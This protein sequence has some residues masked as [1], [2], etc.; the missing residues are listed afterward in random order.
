MCSQPGVKKLNIPFDLLYFLYSLIRGEITSLKWLKYT[1]LKVQTRGGGGS[2]SLIQT[3][4]G[5]R[6]LQHLVKF[7]WKQ[8]FAPGSLSPKKF[9]TPNPLPSRT[10]PNPPPPPPPHT[11]THT[12]TKREKIPTTVEFCTI[13]T[14]PLEHPPPPPPPPPTITKKMLMTIEFCIK[15][16][17][18]LVSAI[19]NS[20]GWNFGQ[21]SA[22]PL[23]W[24]SAN[25]ALT[26][27]LVD[28]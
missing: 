17:T 8:S 25:I 20:P 24:M 28:N 7:S 13:K 4:T 6:L 22:C 2:F 26:T 3:Q 11:H 14:Y 18:N 1:V 12:N 15:K 5:N 27:N 21:I 9:C 10:H 16:I 19:S 23:N